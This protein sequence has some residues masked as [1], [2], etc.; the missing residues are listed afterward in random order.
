M[1]PSARSASFTSSSLNGL[2]MAVMR[3]G[4]RSPWLRRLGCLDRR[5]LLQD[6]VARHAQRR[7]IG[8]ALS[9]LHVVGGCAVLVE[10]QALELAVP[11]DS[12]APFTTDG[13]DRLHRH[14]GD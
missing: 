1:T 6:V 5:D 9:E 7:R 10:V 12:E 13:P 3:W 2:M 14:D 11:G 8:H 4:T